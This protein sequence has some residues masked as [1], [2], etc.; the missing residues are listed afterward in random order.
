MPGDRVI[1]EPGLACGQCR[2]CWEG[3]YNLCPRVRFLG[4]PPTDGL[5][6][7]RVCVPARWVHRLPDALSDAEGAMIEPFAV[8]LQAVAEAGIQPGQSVAILGA[9]PIGLMVLQAARVRGA[10]VLVSIDLA[11]RALDA[12]IAL[13][14][15]AVVNPREVDPVQA[16][17]ELTGGEGAD[18]VVEAVG[19]AATIRQTPDLVRRGGIV[20]LLGLAADPAI[21]LNTHLIVRRGGHLPSRF[22][23]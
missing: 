20:T 18:V 12:A 6:A 15:S 21:P 8:G 5:M 16:V 17:R 2:Y 19:A 22:P 13:G 7:G 3:R 23:Y 9:G 11:L 4:I 1:V 10:S 14:A